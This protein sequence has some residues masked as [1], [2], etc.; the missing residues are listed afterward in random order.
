MVALPMQ[1]AD[2]CACSVYIQPDSPLRL[3]TCPGSRGEKRREEDPKFFAPV[4]VPSADQPLAPYPTL[5]YPTW[6]LLLAK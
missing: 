4:M 3:S 5:P 1:V 2:V 6:W